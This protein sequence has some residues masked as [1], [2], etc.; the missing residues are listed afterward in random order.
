MAAGRAG[1]GREGR[2]RGW[3]ATVVIWATSDAFVND[4][5][6]TGGSAGQDQVTSADTEAPKNRRRVEPIRMIHVR[7]LPHSTWFNMFQE[8]SDVTQPSF[9]PSLLLWPWKIHLLAYCSFNVYHSLRVDYFWNG[10]EQKCDLCWKLSFYRRGSII[11]HNNALTKGSVG[12]FVVYDN[13]I[14]SLN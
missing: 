8:C 3:S 7:F 11:L 1:G 2:G 5:W 4:G 6:R 9:H 14:H 10:I 12:T 13:V